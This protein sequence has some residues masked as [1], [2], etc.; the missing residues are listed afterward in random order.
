MIK[1]KL[2]RLEEIRIEVNNLYAERNAMEKEIIQHFLD[3]KENFKEIELERHIITLKWLYEKEID[4]EKLAELYPDIYVLGLLPTF[5]K[6]HLLKVIDK[7]Q[8]E[9]VLRECTYDTSH[10]K[11][12]MRKKRKKY[13]K[14]ESEAQDE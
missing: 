7:K 6:K 14:K 2:D 4:Y 13:K 5:S 9:L 10:Y 3:N 12:L 11:I 8:A 1:E